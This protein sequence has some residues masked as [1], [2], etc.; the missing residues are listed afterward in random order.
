MTTYKEIQG[1][2]KSSYK[3]NK[4]VEDVGNYKLDKEL[5]TSEAKVFHDPKTDKTIV[6]NRGTANT[7]KD[8]T[9]NAMFI[10]KEYGKTKRFKNAK[11]V[12]EKAI[13]KYGKVDKNIGHSQSG[14]IARKMKKK[15]LTD[16]VIQV[17]PAS[18]GEKNKSNV[19]TIR[20]NNDVVSVLHRKNKNTKELNTGSWNPLYNHSSSILDS[21]PG[22]L[23][24]SG[25]KS[26]FIM[27]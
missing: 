25:Y 4:D 6:A 5:S 20:A 18:L 26:A 22:K 17:N 16:E 13:D 19:H 15:G 10:K 21:T 27:N 23:V 9:N 24:G 7:V 12:Q 3:K 14:V 2:V 11:K 8:W 1:L